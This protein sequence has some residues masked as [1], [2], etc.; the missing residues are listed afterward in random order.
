MPEKLPGFRWFIPCNEHA[1]VVA[2]ITCG[3][4]LMCSLQA[5]LHNGLGVH[6]GFPEWLLGES[7]AI[8]DAVARL[9]FSFEANSVAP[10]A[11]SQAAPP[12]AGAKPET[13]NGSVAGSDDSTALHF[14][15]LGPEWE[16][17]PAG[18]SGQIPETVIAELSIP[19]EYV[20]ADPATDRT[21]SILIQLSYPS[22]KGAV[23][24]QSSEARINAIISATAGKSRPIGPPLF[25]FRF[26]RGKTR[27]PRLDVNGLCGYV[28]TQH[29]GSVGVEFY[30]ACD[31]SRRSFQIFCSPEFNHHR[32][33]SDSAFLGGHIRAQISY[34][35]GMLKERDAI[36]EAVRKLVLSFEQPLVEQAPRDDPKPQ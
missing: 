15:L 27:E 35:I 19:R 3:S 20:A 34:Q 11:T 24:Q 31:E 26:M 16:D 9:T 22:M 14:K 10:P 21:S 6:I 1:S 13:A 4:A 25:S 12:R 2:L 32:P 36:M 5:A 29:P 28:D 7:F 18:Y 8:R 23:G 33:C 30:V 17:W